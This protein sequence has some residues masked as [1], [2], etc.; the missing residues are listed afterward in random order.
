ME[1]FGY[2]PC[3][4]IYTTKWADPWNCEMCTSAGCRWHG[5]YKLDGKGGVVVCQD[6]TGE[7]TFTGPFDTPEK[8]KKAITGNSHAI[9]IKKA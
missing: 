5:P 1:A 7:F 3:C 8:A 4:G 9:V 2:C 6:G